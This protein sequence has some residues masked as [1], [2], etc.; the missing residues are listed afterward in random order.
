MRSGKVHKGKCHVAN[1]FVANIVLVVEGSE[2]IV[3]RLEE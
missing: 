2:K 1:I 3:E